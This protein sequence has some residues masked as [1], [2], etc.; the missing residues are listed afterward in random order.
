MHDKIKSII[1]QIQNID[2]VNFDAFVEYTVDQIPCKDESLG[3]FGLA[4]KN[5]KVRVV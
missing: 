1:R 5:M 2:G 4:T 3:K